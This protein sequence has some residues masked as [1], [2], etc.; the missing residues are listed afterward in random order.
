ME[1]TE[2]GNKKSILNDSQDSCKKNVELCDENNNF[3]M[4]EV[5]E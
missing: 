2:N 5:W 4:S 3:W 1:W